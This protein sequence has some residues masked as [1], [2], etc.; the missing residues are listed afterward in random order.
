APGA[1][2]NSADHRALGQAT[3][4]AVSDAG[5]E[6]IF[7]ELASEGSSPWAGVQWVAIAGSP[8]PTHAVAVGG[9]VEAGVASLAA[10]AA[11]LRALRPEGDDLEAYAREVVGRSVTAAVVGAAGPAVA[12]EVLP[13]TASD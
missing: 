3:M 8:Q 1:P 9:H 5:N 6:W 7:P 13:G 12:F 11:Y 2:W 4:D 10:H